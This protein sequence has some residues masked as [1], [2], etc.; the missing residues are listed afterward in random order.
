VV[1]K[2]VAAGATPV[3]F[4]DNPNFE[5]DLSQCVLFKKRGWIDAG[6]NCNI[7]YSFV[8]E[9]QDSMNRVIDAT[10]LKYPTT[11]VIDPKLVMCNE[12]ECA[13]SIGNTALYKDANHINTKAAIVLAERYL[14]LRGNPFAS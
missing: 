14:T 1:Q 7:P 6:K 12:V 2:I 11:I 4:K 9:T 5:P 8:S 10:K 13:T 3:I